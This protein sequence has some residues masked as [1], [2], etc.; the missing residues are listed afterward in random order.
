M[1]LVGGMTRMP[2]V[3]EKVSELTGKE[4]HQGV[5]P[6]EVVAIGAAIQA[7]VLAGDVKDVLLLDVTPLT[8]GIET[9]GGVM[10]KLIERNT[11]IPTKKSEIFS[12]A[13]DNQPSV[14]IHVLQGEREMADL[15][16]VAGQVP[17]HRHPAGA[18]RAAADRGHLR[19]RRQRH[20]QRLG[21]G[22][23]DGQGAADRDQGRLRARESEVEQMIKDA[24]AHA[25]DDRKQRELAEARNIGENAA[26]QAEKQLVDMGDQVDEAAKAE[27]T[28]A[29]KAV[30]DVLES[31]DAEQIKSRTDALQAAFHKVSEQIYQQ[32]AEQQAA[33]GA[34]TNGAGDAD[35]AEVVDAEVVDDDRA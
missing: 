17:A 14:E 5:N 9:K 13:D 20:P 32:A 27:I 15:Q 25:E 34:A 29:I 30:R 35:E 22:P 3:Q 8:L 18:A 19:H 23:R 24:E 33:D 7:G 16:Q 11:T 6:D 26:Y 10:T 12:T 2:M 21:E 4:P 28:E 31:D 1:V